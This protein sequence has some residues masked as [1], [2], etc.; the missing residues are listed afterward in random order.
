MQSHPSLRFWIRRGKR[1]KSDFKYYFSDF[2]F[3]KSYSL[4]QVARQIN[5]SWVFAYCFL[6]KRC[7]L[8]FWLFCFISFF[9]GLDV[10]LMAEIGETQ[11]NWLL[12]YLG[13]VIGFLF[14]DTESEVTGGGIKW[15]Q[16][17]GERG[18]VH[19]ILQIQLKIKHCLTVECT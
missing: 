12:V 15:L 8:Q 19:K 10:V 14:L 7:I 16:R 1:K 2:K 13:W 9:L 18:K 6:F 5:L 3:S 4:R 11:L 17:E